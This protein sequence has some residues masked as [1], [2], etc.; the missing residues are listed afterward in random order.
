[1]SALLPL[2]NFRVRESPPS[3]FGL[4][5][6]CR[7]SICPGRDLRSLAPA[8]WRI[9]GD[10]YLSGQQTVDRAACRLRTI[11]ARA[12]LRTTM[13]LVVG[14]GHLALGCRN[15]VWGFRSESAI[16]PLIEPV[17]QYDAALR[18]MHVARH[19][20]HVCSRTRV[21]GRGP[22]G[23]LIRNSPVCLRSTLITVS[24]RG[25]DNQRDHGELPDPSHN[26]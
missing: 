4:S 2:I 7:I 10:H 12:H 15:P 25:G 9:A 26:L 22:G 17:D 16:G 19:R 5:G 24:C 6:T 11:N 18:T 23:P 20:R 8:S 14:T 1:M 21:G 3:T 13:G